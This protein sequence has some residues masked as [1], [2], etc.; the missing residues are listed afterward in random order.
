MA[1]EAAASKQE[2]E[3]VSANPPPKAPVTSPSLNE[4]YAAVSPPKAIA[5][6][7][8][9]K[10]GMKKRRSHKRHTKKRRTHKYRARK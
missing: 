6:S 5:V 4:I 8:T 2:A 10:G 3:V 1:Q 7:K 9:Q